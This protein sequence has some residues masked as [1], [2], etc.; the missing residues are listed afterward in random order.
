L[1]N[2]LRKIGRFEATHPVVVLLGVVL[3][4][5][6]SIPGIAS[7]KMV[8][9]YEKMLPSSLE[10]IQTMHMVQDKYGGSDMVQILVEA[11]DVRDPSVIR[12]MMVIEK[13]LEKEDGVIGVMSAAGI[14]RNHYGY[15]P[16]S[17]AAIKKV[18]DSDPRA[19]ALISENYR[20]ALINVRVDIPYEPSK[21]M[22]LIEKVRAGINGAGVQARLGGMIAL[23]VDSYAVFGKDMGII[24]LVGIVLVLSAVILYFKSVTKGLLVLV[25]MVLAITWTSGW[26][27]YLGIPFSFISVGL[28]PILFG[29][30][31]DYGIHLINR[32]DEE[33]GKG[34]STVGALMESVSTVGLGLSIVT[35]TTIA[36]FLGLLASAIPSTQ[37][38]GQAL[39]LGIFF[40]LLAALATVPPVLI[41]K[42]KL[43]V[44]A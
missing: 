12:A 30:G 16:S 18:L 42:E 8:L 43:E 3:F 39:A 36:G 1:K 35:V 6:V 33:V 37:Q 15:L 20:F 17:K 19:K 24:G 40:S 4:T 31:V 21:E 7:I 10:T 28:I 11:E 41:L 29:L 26:M 44:N 34:K 2:A 32:Y 23:D 13:R 14:V 9:N 27:G 25:P 5:L 22:A 38:L